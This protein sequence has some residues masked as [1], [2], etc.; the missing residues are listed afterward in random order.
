[1]IRSLDRGALMERMAMLLATP[2]RD[3]RQALSRW[4]ADAGV[5]LA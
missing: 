3:V 4:A 2:P 5:E 1:M